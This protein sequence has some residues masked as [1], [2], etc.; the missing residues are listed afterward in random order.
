MFVDV[1]CESTSDRPVPTSQWLSR[2]TFNGVIRNAILT[3]LWKP[4]PY[5]TEPVPFWSVGIS[6]IIPDCLSGEMGSTPIQTAR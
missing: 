4:F 5:K 1:A 2:L 3:W 6:A